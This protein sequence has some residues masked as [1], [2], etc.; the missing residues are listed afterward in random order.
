MSEKEFEL[1][2][3]AITLAQEM[4]HDR[5]RERELSDLKNK[6]QMIVNIV[7]IIAFSIILMYD[8]HES[9][10][11][12]SIQNTSTAVTERRETNE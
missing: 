12:V 2:H 4:Q 11:E 8:I 7:L 5:M 6:R 3:S 10:G 1:T 9:Y